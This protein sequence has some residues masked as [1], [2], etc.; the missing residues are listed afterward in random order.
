VDASGLREGKNIKGRGI[1]LL[2]GTVGKARH[3]QAR[4][5]KTIKPSKLGNYRKSGKPRNGHPR[6]GNHV[7]GRRV[8]QSK[9]ITPVR[10]YAS[11][12]RTIIRRVSLP[13]A[14][15][16]ARANSRRIVAAAALLWTS[17]AC[18]SLREIVVRRGNDRP[19]ARFS[20]SG[21]PTDPPARVR[22]SVAGDANLPASAWTAGANLRAHAA[23][24]CARQQWNRS[25]CIIATATVPH[26]WVA[27]PQLAL[28]PLGV[29]V[30]CT[31][32]GTNRRSAVAAR[33]YPSRT[34][35]GRASK[36]WMADRSSSPRRSVL[37]VV[38]HSRAMIGHSEGTTE[39][40][41]HRGQQRN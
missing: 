37:T 2:V 35:A 25:P 9:P 23:A 28:T 19:C 18:S 26:R 16:H 12:R 11:I 6:R 20:R 34:L 4:S 32:L 22:Q 14:L 13:Y 15:R 29:P 1:G 31:S 21:R 3:W 7:E 5:G 40:T 8:T 27:C 41:S 39:S 24:D 38:I 33:R 30:V 36:S 17:F 10:K